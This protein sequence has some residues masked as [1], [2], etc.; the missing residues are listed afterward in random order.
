MA[1]HFVVENPKA[2]RKLLRSVCLSFTCLSECCVLWF[3]LNIIKIDFLIKIVFHLNTFVVFQSSLAWYITLIGELRGGLC[4]ECICLFILHALLF[5]SFSLCLGV[6]FIVGC[7]KVRKAFSKFYRRHSELVEKYNISLRK[8]LQQ[9]ISEP[10]F[11]GD[12]VYRRRKN[13]GKSNFSEQ[14]R[15]LIN[16]CEKIGIIHV[17]Y[18]ADCM[19][20]YQ[21]NL[22]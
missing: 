8:L 1:Y 5:L 6:G 10:K 22:G 17:C 15:K 19:P 21:L 9:G 14:F 2:N 3:S 16:R 13:V 12:L 7:H 11:Y 18:V 4:F 20:S